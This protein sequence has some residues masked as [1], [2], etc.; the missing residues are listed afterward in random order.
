MRD[1]VHK[2]PQDYRGVFK[3]GIEGVL[4]SLSS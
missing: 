1:V 3:A 2:P 4:K